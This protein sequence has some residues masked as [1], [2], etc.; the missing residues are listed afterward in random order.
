M[1]ISSSLNV[2]CECMQMSAVIYWHLHII[3]VSRRTEIYWPLYLLKGWLLLYPT[4]CSVQHSTQDCNHYLPKPVTAPSQSVIR[5][6][7]RAHCCH[8][9]CILPR[10][11][12]HAEGILLCFAIHTDFFLFLYSFGHVSVI[13]EGNKNWNHRI[14]FASWSRL[15][16]IYFKL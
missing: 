3:T 15:W 4:Q 7:V 10:F 14:S 2:S 9:Q 1:L 6:L 12:W 8:L 11:L 16:T 5:S 13:G